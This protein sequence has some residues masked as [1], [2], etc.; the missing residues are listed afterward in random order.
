MWGGHRK[1]FCGGHFPGVLAR[2]SRLSMQYIRPRQ[3][4]L[5][6]QG[7]AQARQ[8][9]SPLPPSPSHR[10]DNNLKL[11]DLAAMRRQN[12]TLRSLCRAA[13]GRLL[14]AMYSDPALLVWLDAPDNRRLARTRT[15]FA[16]SWSCL[17]SCRALQRGRRQGVRSRLNRLANGRRRGPS[18]DRPARRGSENHLGPLCGRSRYVAST[19]CRLMVSTIGQ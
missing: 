15:S 17:P 5:A 13:F 6:R 14:G 18:R 16:S 3:N 2:V 12:Q 1:R 7:S 8:E 9:G 19:R 4:L 10:P 11:D